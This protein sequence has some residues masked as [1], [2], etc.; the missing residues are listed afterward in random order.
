MVLGRILHFASSTV[1]SSNKEKEII[2]LLQNE[3]KVLPLTKMLQVVILA[4][5]GHTIEIDC[6]HIWLLLPY[7]TFTAITTLSN[8]G[9]INKKTFTS[10]FV[11]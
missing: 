10:C 11:M 5:Y 8:N 1:D 9:K 4:F 3:N 6:F 2:Q 7:S